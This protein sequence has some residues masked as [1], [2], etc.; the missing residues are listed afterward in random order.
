[1]TNIA[2]ENNK[3]M[4][5][6]HRLICCAI[7]FL[8]ILSTDAQDFS[9]ILNSIEKNSTYLLA[10]KAETDA[11]NK[12]LRIQTALDAPEVGF[13]YL[14]GN[15]DLGSRK[16]L[17]I[18]Q[19]FDFPTTIIQRNKFVREQQ[20]VATLS[21]LS[22]RQQLL[23]AARKLCIEV[24]YCNAM[25]EHLNE[26]LAETHAMSDAYQK[27]YDKGEA[28][29]IDRNKA[30]QA[31]LFF[32]AEYRE[33]MTTRNNLLE[34]L[35]YMNNGKEVVIVDSAYIHTPLPTSFDEWII[36]NIDR[37]PAL[38]LA[39]GEVAA[40]KQSLSFAKSEWAPKLRVGYMSEFEKVDHYQ[41]ISL[42]ISVPIWSGKRKVNAAKAHLAAAEI[43][44]A[45]TR[46][47]LITQLRGIY[48][49]A[50]QLQETYTQYTKHLT[51][52]DNEKAL[53]KSLSFG[54]ITLITY[55]QERQYVHEM[56][57][58]LI[59]AERDLELRK[60]ELTF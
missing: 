12:D 5:I 9:G 57:E 33:F 49:D 34:Q 22:K 29:I 21:F 8:S 60:A 43:E 53:E 20:R 1:M 39:D 3:T 42:G 17:S 10:Q 47:Q 38:Q 52:C 37:H 55:L 44:Y 18:S 48:N 36:E 14:F 24:V 23:L 46:Q 27:L 32:E 28:T 25:M 40:Q 50:L 2:K 4:S 31:V 35:K 19:S 15:G 7:L 13:N 26:D 16:D 58:K 11:T 6:L 59:T 45:D 54:Q 41:G 51:G 56:H 30:H